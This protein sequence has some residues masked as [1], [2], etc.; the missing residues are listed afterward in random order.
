MR[1]L[2][3]TQDTGFRGKIQKLIASVFPIAH[4]S[5]TNRLGTLNTKNVTT[6]EEEVEQS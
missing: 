4:P 5:G 2:S 1:K 3:I 6:F